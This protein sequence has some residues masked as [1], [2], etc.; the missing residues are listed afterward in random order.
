MDK[1]TNLRAAVEQKCNA[2]LIEDV[3]VIRALLAERDALRDALEQYADPNNWEKD[4]FG[5]RRIWREPGSETPES[6]DGSELA[7]A[8]L[9]QEHS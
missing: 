1:Y 2:I 7:F 5:W 3:D 4:E 6:Y 8:A 9:A